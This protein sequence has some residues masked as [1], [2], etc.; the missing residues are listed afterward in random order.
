MKCTHC[1]VAVPD[2]YR[3]I[4]LGRRHAFC[5]QRCLDLWSPRRVLMLE[6]FANTVFILA[7]GRFRELARAALYGD[8]QRWHAELGNLGSNGQ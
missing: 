2:G 1:G 4:P 6:A 3:S 8:V 5:S 7:R